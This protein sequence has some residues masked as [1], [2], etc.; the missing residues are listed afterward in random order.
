MSTF[1]TRLPAVDQFE[2][3]AEASSFHPVPG[4]WAIVCGDV[5]DSTRAIAEGRYKEVNL[6]G[7]ALITAILNLDRSLDLPFFFAGDGS[8]VLVP[9]ELA[10]RAAR[11][12][13]GLRRIA[14]ERFDL[15]LRAD[16]FPV[17]A[18]RRE[19]FDTRVARFRYTGTYFQAMF[20]GEGLTEAERRLKAAA[21]DIPAD[22]PEPDLAG[23]ECR[24]RGVPSPRGEVVSLLLQAIRLTPEERAAC[25]RDALDF[26]RQTCGEGD[27]V[28][29]TITTNLRLNLS[30]SGL[31]AE[32]RAR[33][34]KAPGWW[35]KLITA[36]MVCETALGGWFMKRRRRALGTDWGRYFDD[37]IRHTDYRKF[38]NLLRMVIGC[39]PAQRAALVEW[40]DAGRAHG[41]LRYG[42]H[43]ASQA[44]LTCVVLD[45]ADRHFH[46]VDGADGGYAAAAKQ[47]KSRA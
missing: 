6:L 31:D 26:I 44:L 29:P 5:I 36:R 24:W 12:L 35:R 7:A 43:V 2:A 15:P 17:A 41:R 1:F 32:A 9:P 34:G 3:L 42:L 38:D 37:V 33:H 21:P 28:R 46:F 13:P 20:A 27:S 22:A 23:L 40:L 19:G 30:R 16:V 18:L 11:V 25:Y 4:E 45:R 39:T 14:Q 10:A 47:M 8:C